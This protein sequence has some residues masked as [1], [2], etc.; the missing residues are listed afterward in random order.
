MAISKGLEALLSLQNQDFILLQLEADIQ[1]LSSK[2][3]KLEQKASQTE[4]ALSLEQAN[5][6]ALQLKS[7]NN[8][9]LIR[10]KED[11]RL[12]LKT[13]QIQIKKQNEYEAFNH[14]LDSLQTELS[15][16]ESQTLE[17]LLKLDQQKA[18]LEQYTQETALNLEKY[19]QE[20]LAHQDAIRQ[21]ETAKALAEEAATK[22]SEL[23]PASFLSAYKALKKTKTLPLVVQLVNHQCSGCHLRVSNELNQAVYQSQEPL[24]CDNCGRLVYLV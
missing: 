19:K 20:R 8:E 24:K 1:Y 13:Q 23:V 9:Q 17:D 5:F 7:K 11:S 18:Q 12:R 21:K 22:L 2:L 4:A 16:L 6:K 10:D 15:S 3:K 14:Q